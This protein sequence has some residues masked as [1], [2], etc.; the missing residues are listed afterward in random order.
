MT[1]TWGVLL[2]VKRWLIKSGKETWSDFWVE[3]LIA[4]QYIPFENF[5]VV[6]LCWLEMESQIY[7]K[8]DNFFC[9]PETCSHIPLSQ[10]KARLHIFTVYRTV[11]SQCIEFHKIICHNLSWHCTVTH[12]LVSAQVEFME[13]AHLMLRGWSRLWVGQACIKL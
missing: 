5:Q 7:K 1:V 6:Y 4:T 3:N 9:N 2:C 12:A 13:H 8:V 10:Q 11:F